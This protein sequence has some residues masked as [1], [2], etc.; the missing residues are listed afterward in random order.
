[1]RAIS[2]ERARLS[3]PVT[4]SMISGAELP[5]TMTGPS[6]GRVRSYLGIAAVEGESRR[7][8]GP[9]LLDHGRWELDDLRLGIHLAAVLLEDR[10]RLFIPHQ[11]ADI[12]EDLQGGGVRAFDLLLGE[13]G[14]EVDQRILLGDQAGQQLHG[15]LNRK[16]CCQ[17]VDLIDRKHLQ[18]RTGHLEGGGSRGKA[19]R[20]LQVPAL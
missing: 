8:H 3:R 19:G 20:F 17:G 5:V 14:G 2:S 16:L 7:Q 18:S 1:M 13:K 4:G 6:C 15:M 12:L 9:V 10:A 11:Q